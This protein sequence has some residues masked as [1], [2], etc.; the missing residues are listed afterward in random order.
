M[1]A[2]A[3]YDSNLYAIDLCWNSNR[4]RAEFELSIEY[5]EP[6]AWVELREHFYADTLYVTVSKLIPRANLQIF[7]SPFWGS[8]FNLW[9]V[10]LALWIRLL[11]ELKPVEQLWPLLWLDQ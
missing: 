1:Q 4:H 6:S 5:P 11:L 8:S 2:S 3:L 7:P 10:S 9:P